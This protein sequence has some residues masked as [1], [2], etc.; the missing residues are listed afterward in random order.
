MPIWRFAQPVNYIGFS[1]MLITI[2]LS[3][4]GDVHHA[5]TGV[6]DLARQRDRGVLPHGVQGPRLLVAAPPEKAW[7]PLW[8]MLFVTIACGAISGWHALVGSVGTARQLEYETDGL[9]ARREARC[10]AST[11]SRSSLSPQSPSPGVGG[12]G[13]RFAAGVGK[14]IF[15]GTFGLIPGDLRHRAQASALRHDRPHRDRA[16]LPRHARDSGG[17]DGRHPCRS[18]GT[19]RREHHLDG[20]HGGPRPHGHVGLP[21]ADVRRLE[22]AHGRSLASSS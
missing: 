8:P 11:R 3:A 10:S 13:G 12:G 21:L 16:R 17:M 9:P 18:S 6:K 20:A 5:L 14:L 19:A 15:A 1:I 7:Q 22:P 4:I 2:V